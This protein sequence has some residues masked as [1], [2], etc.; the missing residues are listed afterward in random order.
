M[1]IFEAAALGKSGRVI[2]L[3]NEKPDLDSA[4][5]PDGFTHLGLVAFFSNPDIVEV[6][7]E[8]GARASQP[9]ANVTHVQPLH[10]AAASQQLA[11]A[12]MLINAGAVVNARQQHDFTPLH[13]AA[14]N[15]QHAMVYLL[16]KWDADLTA[17]TE[18]G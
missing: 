4:Y 8:H 6:L 1:D 16:L 3:L 7:L 14:A 15:G 11:I 5:T 9:S 2:N 12:E 13:A 10:S 17:A 18:N